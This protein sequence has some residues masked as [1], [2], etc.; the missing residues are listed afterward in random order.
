MVHHLGAIVLYKY[1]TMTAISQWRPKS[2]PPEAAHFARATVAA[3]GPATKARAKALLFAASRLGAFA[4]GAGLELRPEV[5]FCPAVVER[6][7]V[8]NAK[9]LSGPTR[10]TL[11]T[12]CR[13]LGRALEAYPSPAPVPLPRERAKAPYT[14][15]E[16]SAYLALADAQ[17]TPARRNKANALIC[18]GAGAGLAG[19][20]LRA[21]RGS[22]V[23]ARSG[24]VVVAVRGRRARTVPV[25]ARYH[26]RLLSC[27]AVGAEELLVG[28][29]SPLRRNVTT[30]V[31]GSLAG[32]EGLPRLEVARLRAT[33]LAEVADAIGLPAFM[34]AAGVS[35]S[36]RLGDI[37]AGLPRTSEEAAV[38]WLGGRQP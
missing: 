28:G 2:V 24:G 25:L 6:F 3:A 38:A 30:P 31:V 5:V 16:I 34:G 11:R 33:W 27:A 32:G 22:D 13:A 12:N 4:L 14:A 37:V 17:P 1:N 7:I 8:A 26:G 18:L 15:R 21:L 9:V 35:C 23:M 29:S 19:A 36:Q 20:D 10:R